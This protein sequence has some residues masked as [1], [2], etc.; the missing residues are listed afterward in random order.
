MFS[1]EHDINNINNLNDNFVSLPMPQS[2]CESNEGNNNVNNISETIKDEVFLTAKNFNSSPQTLLPEN[3]N[4]LLLLDGR[5]AL[6]PGYG[7][8][9]ATSQT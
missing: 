5:S 6:P 7:F 2:V 8:G 1:F 9:N 3:G 4:P